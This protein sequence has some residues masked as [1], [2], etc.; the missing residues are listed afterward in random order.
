VLQDQ[1]PSTQQVP[2]P[3]KKKGFFGKIAG[4]FKGDDNNRNSGDSRNDPN[5]PR[6]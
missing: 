3:Q 2:P 4:V 5:Q 6:K 1:Q